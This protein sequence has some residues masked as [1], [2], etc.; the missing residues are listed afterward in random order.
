MR[1][2]PYYDECLRLLTGS[3]HSADT[4]LVQL[5]RL[6]LVHEK[7]IHAPWHDLNNP[8]QREYQPGDHATEAAKITP[9]APASFYV[10]ALQNDLNQAREQI[11]SE[12]RQ[13][14]ILALY[15][16]NVE[17]CIHE[18]AL[19]KAL[20][21]GFQRLES[22]WAALQAIKSWYELFFRFSPATYVGVSMGVYAQFAHCLVALSRL[23][24]FEHPD[25]DLKLARETCNLSTILDQIIDRFARVK[26]EA[27]LDCS[28]REDID[29][30]SSNS[31]RVTAIKQWWNAKLAAEQSTS[32]ETAASASDQVDEN[33]AADPML[34]GPPIDFSDDSWLRDILSLDD[35][36]FSQFL[37]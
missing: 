19:S 14:E 16:Y 2:L 21:P 28:N 23:S 10:K 18:I 36:Q 30:F 13:N 25:W 5:V 34:T 1:W 37:Q 33:I 22:L 8:V 6:Q 26:V 20:D 15:G 4:F 12:L 32:T 3:H 29:V 11:P 7:V 24:S 31:R 27:N 9:S 17:V 35:N